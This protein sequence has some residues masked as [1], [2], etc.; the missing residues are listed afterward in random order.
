MKKVSFNNN[1]QYIPAGKIINIKCLPTRKRLPS[2]A[3]YCV[4]PTSVALEE[5]FRNGSYEFEM[6][7]GSKR[8][9]VPPKAD[10]A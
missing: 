5:R 3:V 9:Q 4:I 7:M 10:I 8:L 2:A 1:I 6:G